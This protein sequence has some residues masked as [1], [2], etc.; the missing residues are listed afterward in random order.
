MRVT[1]SSLF[2]VFNLT[3]VPAPALL[4]PL[5]WDR[6]RLA[7]PSCLGAPRDNPLV[8]PVTR[9]HAGQATQTGSNFKARAGELSCMNA[10]TQTAVGEFMLIPAGS[11]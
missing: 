10:L 8:A 2:T 1:V 7:L 9:G 4:P 11:D 5:L 6:R 3:A